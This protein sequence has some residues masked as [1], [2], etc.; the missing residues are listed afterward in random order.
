MDETDRTQRT[1]D[2]IQAYLTL[3]DSLRLSALP[4]W[5]S[6][7]LNLSQLKALFLLEYHGSMTVSE[8]ARRLEMGNS[9]ASILIQQLVEQEL[10]ERSEDTLDRRR[11]LV[12]LTPRGT[13]LIVGRREN[14][15]INLLRWLGEM[16][17]EDLA[18]L[19]SG[20][21]ALVRVMQATGTQTPNGTITEPV[22]K[23]A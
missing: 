21:Q 6:A 10:V 12:R 5:I 22:Q 23:Q 11:T 16:G 20:L 19:Q 17:E 13:G 3:G 14:I 15:K 2:V 1:N 8:L 7:E 18:C 9:A 4:N